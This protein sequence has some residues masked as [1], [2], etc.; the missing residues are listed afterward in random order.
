MLHITNIVQNTSA[1]FETN[2]NLPRQK[3]IIPPFLLHFFVLRTL[4]MNELFAIRTRYFSQSTRGTQSTDRRWTK[5]RSHT[6]TSCSLRVWSLPM[7]LTSQSRLGSSSARRV[8][9]QWKF[10]QGIPSIFEFVCSQCF[11]TR[12]TLEYSHNRRFREAEQIFT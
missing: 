8:D 2:Y 11:D 3:D 6:R 12:Q 10:Q 7:H 1:D 9:G 4:R 5:Q